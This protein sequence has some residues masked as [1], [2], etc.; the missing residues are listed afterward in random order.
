MRPARTSGRYRSS[1]L[2]RLL[3]AVIGPNLPIL[4]VRYHSKFRGISGLSSY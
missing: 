3:T 1:S 4:D 2:L